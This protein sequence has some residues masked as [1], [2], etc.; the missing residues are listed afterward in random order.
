[1]IKQYN[2]YRI[3][4]FFPCLST[5]FPDKPIVVDTFRRRR[6]WIVLANVFRCLNR[7]LAEASPLGRALQTAVIA[8]GPILAK[9]TLFL[10]RCK[11]DNVMPPCH[12]FRP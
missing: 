1:M 4:L 9:A 3:S 11:P 12:T 7:A 6:S 10:V 2:P 5:K 8:Y